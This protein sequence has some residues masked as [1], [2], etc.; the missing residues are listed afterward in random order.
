MK[1]LPDEKGKAG[2]RA[3]AGRHQ[4]RIGLIV[5]L[6]SAVLMAGVGLTVPTR[7]RA[8][9]LD[10]LLCVGLLETPAVCPLAISAETV[11]QAAVA[12]AQVAPPPHVAGPH[13]VGVIREPG[14][15]PTHV[16]R[17]DARRFPLGGRGRRD[18]RRSWRRRHEPPHRGAA[19]GASRP[20]WTSTAS[21]RRWPRISIARTAASSS[22]SSPGVKRTAAAPLF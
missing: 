12:R 20:E 11:T 10:G 22:A 8:S 5:F 2:D 4:E 19:G 18:K 21:G 6:A 16:L 13:L 1:D 3:A 9:P 15:H 7:P 17:R 14:L